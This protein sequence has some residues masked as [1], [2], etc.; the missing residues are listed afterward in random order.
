MV[1]FNHYFLIQKYLYISLLLYVATMR[2]IKIDKS[3]L[4]VRDDVIGFFEKQIT[5]HGNGA[6]I[7]CPKLFIGKKAYVIVRK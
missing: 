2:R 7:M 6:K 1:F 5:Q 3:K 4:I